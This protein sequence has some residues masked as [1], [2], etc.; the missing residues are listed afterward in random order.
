MKRHLKPFSVEIKKS[1]IQGQRSQIPSKHVFERVTAH[2]AKVFRKEEP[3]AVAEPSVAPRILPSIVEPVWSSSAAVEPVRREHSSGLKATR[4]Q[5]ESDLNPT[6]SENVEDAP[7]GTPAITKALLQTDVAPAVEEDTRPV[8][9][10]QSV[11]GESVKARLRQ[12]RKKA[13]RAIEQVMASEPMPGLEQ[14]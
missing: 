1:R 5:I 13:S 9:D 4:R 2:V 6:A 12:P 3:Q 14:M 10:V 7:A 8:H 11:E